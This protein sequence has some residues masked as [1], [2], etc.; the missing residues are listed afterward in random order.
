VLTW[1]VAPSTGL[2][3]PLPDAL[4]LTKTPHIPFGWGGGVV[5]VGVGMGCATSVAVVTGRIDPKN[6]KLRLVNL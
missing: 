4:S 5:Q 6:E 3:A 2:P 1:W